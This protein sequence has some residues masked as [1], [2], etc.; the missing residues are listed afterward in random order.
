MS[1]VIHGVVHGNTI[2]LK[3]SSGVPDGEEV[4]VVLKTLGPAALG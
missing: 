2:E 1:N 4:E 3:E